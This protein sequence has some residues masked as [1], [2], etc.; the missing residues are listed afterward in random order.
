M[1]TEN[2]VQLGPGPGSGPDSDGGKVS[3]GA[4]MRPGAAITNNADCTVLCLNQCET[5]A[6]QMHKFL[7]VLRNFTSDSSVA[8]K[9]SILC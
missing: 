6:L 5:N 3:I 1:V 9:H 8:F 7:L 2:S 4:N